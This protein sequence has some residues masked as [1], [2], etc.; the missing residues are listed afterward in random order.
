MTIRER[1]ARKLRNHPITL[2]IASEV[3]KVPVL[4]LRTHRRYRMPRLQSDPFE[5]VLNSIGE[6]ISEVGL[7]LQRNRG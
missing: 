4:L 1:L 6:F 7:E 3:L 2:S 5:Q